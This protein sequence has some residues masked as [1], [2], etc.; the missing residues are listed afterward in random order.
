MCD[1]EF[2]NGILL[3]T[4]NQERP[5]AK[6]R[7]QRPESKLPKLALRLHLH[8]QVH[9]EG[10]QQR[11]VDHQSGITLHLAAVVHI[12]MN[13]VSVEG[14][15]GV[16]EE[17][18][19]IWGDFSLHVRILRGLIRFADG[20]AWVRRSAE[21]QFLLLLETRFLGL[22]IRMLDRDKHKWPGASGFQ[23]HI[24][25]RGTSPDPLPHDQRLFEGEGAAC[26]HAVESGDRWQEASELGV[27]VPADLRDFRLGDPQRPVK[28]GR[29][30]EQIR[31]VVI[32]CS[33]KPLNRSG[34]DKILCRFR[35]ANPLL[36][37]R[38]VKVVIFHDLGQYERGSPST[39]SAR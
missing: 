32:E 16:A 22:V 30:V 31:L 21:D 20:L 14:E 25:D 3:A 6:Y 11:P 4:T 19:R 35:V 33:L 34:R 9:Q 29:S 24:G 37:V 28:S 36:E 26:P 10:R 13:A 2:Q 27:S 5:R 17:H 15:G 18:H 8:G 7:V 23:L 38:E 39:C 1:P 12:V